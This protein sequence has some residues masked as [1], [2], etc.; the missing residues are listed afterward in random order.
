MIVE[1]GTNPEPHTRMSETDTSDSTSASLE[2]MD[3][4]AVSST[5]DSKNWVT[6]PTSRN[7]TEITNVRR[8]SSTTSRA[9][10]ATIGNRT[11]QTGTE[12]ATDW[13][14]TISRIAPH[15]TV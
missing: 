10:V 2:W 13:Y 3:G 15:S 5:N 7:S 11:G 1:L 9:R 14:P 8:R 4:K 6:V 12:P